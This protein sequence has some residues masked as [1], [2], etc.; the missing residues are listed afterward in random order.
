MGERVSGAG[1]SGGNGGNIVFP[2]WVCWRV[3]PEMPSAEVSSEASRRVCG[4]ESAG[5][6]RESAGESVGEQGSMG[7]MGAECRG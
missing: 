2:N 3:R 1:G 5:S 4:R 6:S 7:S